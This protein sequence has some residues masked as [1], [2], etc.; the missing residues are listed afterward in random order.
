MTHTDSE[1]VIYIPVQRPRTRTVAQ[2]RAEARAHLVDAAGRHPGARRSLASASAPSPV[3]IRVPK[4]V[5][6]PKSAR[7]S[8]SRQPRRTAL[9][10]HRRWI[11]A[12]TVVVVLASAPRLWGG[13]A[14]A[15]QLLAALVIGLA[16]GIATAL[17]RNRFDDHLRGAADLADSTGCLVLAPIDAGRE[18]SS[19]ARAAAR[20]GATSASRSYAEL[21]NRVMRSHSDHREQRLLVTS[22]SGHAQHVVSVNL[23]NAFARAGKSVVVMFVDLR[24]PF[25]PPELDVDPS[26]TLAAV[27]HGRTSLSDAMQWARTTDLR[28]LPTGTVD[29]RDQDRFGSAIRDLVAKARFGADVVIIDAPAVLSGSANLLGIAEVADEVLLAADIRHTTRTQAQV[30]AARLRPLRPKL[31]GWVLESSSTPVRLPPLRTS[32]SRSHPGRV[33]AAAPERPRLGL[34]PARPGSAAASRPSA[35]RGT[36]HTSA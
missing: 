8:G 9:W 36:D 20:R 28:L 15:L 34:P 6:V 4:V 33:S 32:L 30:T 23:A 26:R 27:L 18:T 31:R 14:P 12:V 22:P 13:S 25:A 3:S 35:P 17:L 11:A 7:R 24:H 10:R 29:E 19:P 5:L 16:L 1:Q 21:A 2:A